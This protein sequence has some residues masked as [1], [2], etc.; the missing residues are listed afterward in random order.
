LFSFSFS[1]CF[2]GLA[3]VTIHMRIHYQFSTSFLS[4]SHWAPY[5]QDHPH[6]LSHYSRHW[7]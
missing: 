1:G 4:V 7:A 3:S 2:R 6:D 5:S